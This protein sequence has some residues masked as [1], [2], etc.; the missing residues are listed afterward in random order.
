MNRDSQSIIDDLS[1]MMLT[2]NHGDF[3]AEAIASILGQTRPPAQ[4]VIW[5]DHSP[6]HTWEEVERAITDYSGPVDILA[7][8][9][10]Q[11]LGPAFNRHSAW[12]R[13]DRRYMVTAHGDD[14]SYPKRLERIRQIFEDTGATTVSHNAWHYWEGDRTDL[15]VELGNGDGFLKIDD[16]CSMPF[17]PTVLGATLAMDRAVFE[18]FPATAPPGN[19][20]VGP[21]DLILPLRGALLGGHW[22]TE[23]PLLD[24]RRH[25]GQ[26]TAR[27]FDLDSTHPDAPRETLEAFF[28]F[29]QLQ[30]MRD[31]H[32]YRVNGGDPDKAARARRLTID[33]W[34]KRLRH[35]SFAH[36]R[37]EAAGWTHEW[38]MGN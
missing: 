13:I 5:D 26:N 29:G 31:I 20:A 7:H 11:R 35:W 23:E 30:R 6:D 21:G 17:M 10:T 8:R 19:A 9:Q 36:Q 4:L 38:V 2:F 3:V 37:L 1:V 22:Y 33:T 24:W 28:V 14:I 34:L 25:P 15:N 12:K 27:F 18:R 16:I 32:H